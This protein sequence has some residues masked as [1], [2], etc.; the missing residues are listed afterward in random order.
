MSRQPNVSDET[1]ALYKQLADAQREQRVLIS[2]SMGIS[3]LA[4]NDM[5]E[6]DKFVTLSPTGISVS[7]GD[8][9][10][11]AGSV[12]VRETLFG[13]PYA[14]IG[15]TSTKDSKTGAVTSYPASTFTA[16]GAEGKVLFQ[17]P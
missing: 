9:N 12:N 14:C 6:G 7:K 10:V 2:A 11:I 5:G 8:V 15:K 4:A 3:V 13:G 16:Y 1:R 17:A